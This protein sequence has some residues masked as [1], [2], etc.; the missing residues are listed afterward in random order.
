MK[1]F[2]YKTTFSS[3][4]RPVSSQERDKYLSVASLDKLRAF[5]P[6]IDL[7]KNPDILPISFDAAIINRC[8][9]N[10]DAITTETALLV[11]SCFPNKF[12]DIEHNRQKIIG[13]ITNA[14]FSAF[15]T[16]QPLTAEEVKDLKK[17]FNLTLGG[18]LWRVVNPDLS[19]MVEESNDPN[20]EYFE[21]ISASWELGFYDFDIAEL[22]G[23]S[24][25]LEDATFI[26]DPKKVEE[27]SASLKAY[28]GTGKID[29][30]RAV[31]VPKGEVMA[32]GIGLTNSPAAEVQGVAVPTSTGVTSTA[33]TSSNATTVTITS[34]FAKVNEAAKNSIDSITAV[35][36]AVESINKETISQPIE[37]NVK[38]DSPTM[39]ITNLKDITEDSLKQVTASEI[40]EFINNE[41]KVANEAYV[42]EKTAT[43]DALNKAQKD[44]E[45]LLAETKANKEVAD[46]LAKKIEALEKEAKARE[47]QAQFTTR[48]SFINTKWNLDED[49]SKVVASEIGQMTDEAFEKYSKNLTVMLKGKEK[50][51]V[52]IAST[53][54]APE[55]VI[56]A[57]IK[58]GTVDKQTVPNTNTSTPSEYERFKTAFS[59]ENWV[60]T[61]SRKR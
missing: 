8:N 16:N 2:K 25:N 3:I 19:N 48:M 37:K 50:T 4:I 24:K 58:N 36:A 49:M 12:I 45:I 21:K 61:N 6:N 42:K 59:P 39:K 22:S 30:K 33:T 34:Q 47:I 7:F 56:E 15:G 52:A 60:L 29:G 57:A 20:S 23:N 5:I 32:L 17:P 26:T 13:V 1:D 54:V 38:K 18:L 11:A 46:A 55:V 41:L 40:S 9:L 14:S 51:A 44:N 31:R 10:D 27:A 43:Q 35:I 53:E 28:G